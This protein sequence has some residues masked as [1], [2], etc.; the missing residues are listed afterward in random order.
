MTNTPQAARNE[1][2]FVMINCGWEGGQTLA[3][4]AVASESPLYSTTPMPLIHS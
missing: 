3:A 2:V 1:G 4:A